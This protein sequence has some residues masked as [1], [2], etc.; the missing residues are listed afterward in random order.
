MM[1]QVITILLLGNMEK[2]DRAWFILP[3]VGFIIYKD[4]T[5]E[6]AL[7]WLKWT[8]WVKW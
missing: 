4:G 5:R 6:I 3:M 1:M 2:M 7:G 8:L